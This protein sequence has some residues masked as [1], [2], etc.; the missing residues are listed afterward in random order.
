MLICVQVHN[1]DLGT[2]HT[3]WRWETNIERCDRKSCEKCE[4]ELNI[5][6]PEYERSNYMWQDDEGNSIFFESEFPFGNQNEDWEEYYAMQREEYF[7]MQRE[8]Y[9]VMHRV[10]HRLE[11]TTDNTRN[12]EECLDH[13]DSRMITWS[14]SCII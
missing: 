2:S 11:N 13:I 10:P 12:I 6:N 3:E 9:Y 14:N 5:D 4:D 1:E 7:A 8:E